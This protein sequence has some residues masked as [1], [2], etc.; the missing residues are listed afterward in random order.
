[1][2][3]KDWGYLNIFAK[4][5]TMRKILSVTVLL[6]LATSALFAKVICITDHVF[7]DSKD[8]TPVV[9]KIFEENPDGNI[10]LHFPKG[11]Y[12]FYTDYAV[13]KYHA[14]TNHDNT[15]KHIAFPIMNME[16]V[17]IN[18]NGSDF[19]FHGVIIPFLIEHS[20]NI[21]LSNLSIDWEE[22]FYTQAQ[23]I[24]SSAKDRTIDLKF[25]DFSCIK[26]E[27]GRLVLT[28]NGLTQDILGQSMVFDPKT[29]A[30]AY[31]ATDYLLGETFNY[32]CSAQKLA[33][34]TYR[35]P[36]KFHRG[37]VPDGMIYIMKGPHG[38]NRLAPAIH[39]SAAK[40][41]RLNDIDIHHAGGMGVIGERSEN[42]HLNNVDIC[43]REETDRMVTTTADATHFCNCKGQL[44]IENC[45][46]E[47]MLDDGTNVHGTY[48]RVVKVLS[49]TSV[50]AKINHKQQLGFD[51]ANIGDEIKIVDAQTILTKKCAK[52]SSIKSL[53]D[54]YI[55]IEFDVSVDGFV[56][57]DDGLENATWY[58][59][60]TFRNNTVR[61]NRARSILL[62][63][64]KKMLIENNTFSSMMTSILFEGD[65]DHWFESGAVSDVTIQNNTF[66]DCCYGG[67][68][69]GS[70][71]WINP[72]IKSMP[73]KEYYE[74]IIKI[75]NNRFKSF[76]RSILDAKSVKFLVFENNIIEPSGT[77]PQLHPECPEV[78]I[79][80]IG[81]FSL[82]KNKYIGHKKAEYEIKD[83]EQTSISNNSG[84]ID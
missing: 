71:I 8:Y 6:C 67:G 75:R 55:K 3:Q 52:V 63:S 58:P 35:I 4:K 51:F 10:T 62:S 65:L 28:Y 7:S 41:I 1:M 12:H 61:N 45:L 59:E 30:V 74:G 21:K 44:L 29:N 68:K 50:L 77:Y 64:G 11:E 23:V 66:L 83:T 53:N 72:H 48:A 47:N 18:G 57:V 46:F 42:I 22:P 5:Q 25:T 43:L 33:E 27:K 49:E 84:F 2:Y 40:D 79:M 19:I 13:A 73:E 16:N 17:E 80:H 36:A 38:E 9:R 39:L 26:Q 34:N 31:K 20:H 15:Y 60:L 54:E 70:L 76:D 56:S 24:A 37:Q 32:S 69:K 14:V 82:R 78:K 81:N